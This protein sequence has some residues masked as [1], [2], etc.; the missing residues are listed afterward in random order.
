MVDDIKHMLDTIDTA[1]GSA[2]S[3][4]ASFADAREKLQR[5][6]DGAARRV[7]IE[8]LATG[9]KEMELS[10]KKLE[11]RLTASRQEIEHLQQNLEVVRTE[12]LADPLTTLA[13]RKFFDV[14]LG[15]AVAEAR[16]NG[17]PLTLLMCDI[18]HFKAFN[19]KF[20]HVAG[21][22]VPR[23]VAIR[24]SRRAMAA[25]S[26]SSRCRRRRCRRRSP[27]PTTFAV[28]S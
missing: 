10:N 19:D 17:E 16:Q 20:G 14:E 3:Y 4:S 13:N 18:D 5:A 22:Q 15:K 21:D 26:S 28:P 6:N 24:W 27:S 25:K 7:V 23:L 12:S 2:I 1:A 11:S 8:R 9:A